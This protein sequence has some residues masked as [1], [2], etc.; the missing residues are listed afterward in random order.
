[1]IS[2]CG[3]VSTS[4]VRSIQIP[5]V[6]LKILFRTRLKLCMFSF[7][8]VEPFFFFCLRRWDRRDRLEKRLLHRIPT[9]LNGQVLSSKTC[10]EIAYRDGKLPFSLSL[11]CLCAH[12]VTVQQLQASTGRPVNL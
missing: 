2:R 12:Q 5:Q 6:M 7:I 10:V 8:N 11:H 4:F 9:V 3:E 1:M